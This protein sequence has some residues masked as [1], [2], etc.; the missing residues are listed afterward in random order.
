MLETS[1]YLDMMLRSITGWFAFVS[2]MIFIHDRRSYEFRTPGAIGV[3][4]LAFGMF[5]YSTVSLFSTVSML[6]KHLGFVSQWY[7][8]KFLSGDVW[9]YL[10]LGDVIVNLSIGSIALACRMTVSTKKGRRYL[11][12]KL[13]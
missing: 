13:E 2:L 1:S 5:W 7:V 11:H 6:G 10:M 8:P 12:G 3:Q 4:T 9:F